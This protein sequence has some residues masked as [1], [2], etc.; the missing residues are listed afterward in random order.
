MASLSPHCARLAAGLLGE[1]A[2]LVAEIDEFGDAHGKLAEGAGV[3][4]CAR[5]F[6]SAITMSIWSLILRSL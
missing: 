3:V 2:Q 1:R 6:Q 4:C 5:F